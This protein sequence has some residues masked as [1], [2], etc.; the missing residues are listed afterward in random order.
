MNNKQSKKSKTKFL[1]MTNSNAAGIDVG[2]K[3]HYVCVPEDRDTNCVRKFECFTEDLNKMVKWLRECEITTIAMESTGIFWIPLYQL[4]ERAGFEV[5]LIN[6]QHIKNVPGRK[7]TDVEDCRWI[8]KLHSYGLLRS[9]FRPE[10]EV[11]VLRSYIRQRARLIESASTHIL[12]MQKALTEMNIQLHNVISDI[13]GVTGMAIIKAIISG[14]RDPIKLAQL[15]D[16]RIK[17]SR[18]VVAK[19]LLGDYREEHLFV[20]K[21]EV[22]LYEFYYKQIENL[23]KEI[24]KCY[25]KFD[26]K[27][28]AGN[29]LK[30]LKVQRK[31][32]SGNKPKFNLRQNLYK[33]TGVDLTEIPGLNALTIQTIISEVGIN[34]D[35]WPS[36]KHFTSWL[37]LSPANR[38][39]GE[40]IMSSRTR[41][42]KNK[43]TNAFRMAAYTVGRTQT[44]LGAF[45]RRVK[46]KAGGPKA[47]T[48][49]ARKIACLFYR[50]LKYG[51]HY[52]E[53]GI[54]YYE[55]KYNE[56]LKRVLDKIAKQLGY[57]VVANQHTS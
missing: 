54:E 9:S 41:K 50:L 29:S 43:A 7:K 21:Q 13:T 19:S 1:K 22:E 46:S 3:V 23:D 11:C 57:T 8:Q 33:I 30:S 24:E 10:D 45:M 5:N 12:R 15:R 52:V 14:E 32:L 44:A 25:K 38:I 26:P 36:E 55:K 6:A 40:K 16:G 31:S 53:L 17:N 4:L 51:A 39:T 20:L 18:E 2:S 35:K 37:G 48:A 34:M 49:T 28:T 56:N 42:V 47:I 27:D